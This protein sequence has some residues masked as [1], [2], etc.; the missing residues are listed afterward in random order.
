MMMKMQDFLL[1]GSIKK[2]IA[3]LLEGEQAFIILSMWA[4]HQL[5][6]AWSYQ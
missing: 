4:K 6:E 1:L 5:L 3:S 2:Q